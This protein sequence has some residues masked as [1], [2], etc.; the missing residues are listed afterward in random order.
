MTEERD[1]RLYFTREIEPGCVFVW[2]TEP[3]L[4]GNITIKGVEYE[5]AGVRKR[6]TH[7]GRSGDGTEQC[8]SG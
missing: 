7:D 2:T 8:D 5:I 3:H 6:A 1:C 4:T